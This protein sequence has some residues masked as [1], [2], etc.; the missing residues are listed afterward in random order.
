MFFF[1]FFAILTET[2]RFTDWASKSL[3]SAM[4]MLSLDGGSPTKKVLVQS[5]W[6]LSTELGNVTI[7][8]SLVVRNSSYKTPLYSCRSLSKQA[9]FFLY[10]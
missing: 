3:S 10:K 7:P 1:T 8:S 4:V 9:I 5:L 2:V 6:N